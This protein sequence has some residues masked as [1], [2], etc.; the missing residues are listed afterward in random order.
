MQSE[1]W[2]II[3]YM[4]LFPYNLLFCFHVLQMHGMLA[5]SLVASKDKYWRIESQYADGT[6]VDLNRVIP[7]FP[8]LSRLLASQCN[9]M[10][11]SR[12]LVEQ[13]CIVLQVFVRLI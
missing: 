1:V 7:S 10:V 11:F 12:L 4:D 6:M 3:F 8:I 5:D 2:C 13:S 9:I